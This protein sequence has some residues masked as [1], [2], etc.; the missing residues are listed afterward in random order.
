MLG[1][2]YKLV[3]GVQDLK[4]AGGA[5]TYYARDHKTVTELDACLGGPAEPLDNQL[6]CAVDDRR[7]DAAVALTWVDPYVL[8]DTG[9]AG[10]LAFLH[11]GDRRRSRYAGGPPSYVLGSGLLRR[12]GES[13]DEPAND[14][15]VGEVW[16]YPPGRKWRF[17][18]SDS[19][20]SLFGCT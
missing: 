15:H 2:R 6:A 9:D 3:L 17:G 7:L 13:V 1:P 4:P 8:D 11:V 20:R 5:A 18:L 12:T 14:L 10:R 16:Q 19:R